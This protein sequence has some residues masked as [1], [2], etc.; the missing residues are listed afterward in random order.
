VTNPI[1][2]VNRIPEPWL[3]A[4]AWIAAALLAVAVL[5]HVA[6]YGTPALADPVLTVTFALFSLIFPVFGAAVAL[7][8]FG[9]LN[10]GRLMATMPMAVRIASVLVVAYIA[11][12]FFR[13]IQLLPGQPVAQ[14]GSFY[15]NDHGN[16][17]PISFETYRQGLMYEARL[18]SGHE[19]FFLGVAALLGHQV[20]RLRRGELDRGRPPTAGWSFVL[21]PPLTSR[22]TYSV[23]LTATE[24]ASRLAAQTAQGPAGWFGQ[25][26]PLSGWVSD[27]RFHLEL[28]GA[29]NRQLSR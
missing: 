15:L 26:R 21:P 6:T 17:I 5:T 22:V 1:L 25:T 4:Y 2:D 16:N 19:V 8:A 14:G 18:F 24:A 28:G 9:R 7:T 29:S 11:V 10:V 12:D 3:R 23:P 13:M 20:D 27:S